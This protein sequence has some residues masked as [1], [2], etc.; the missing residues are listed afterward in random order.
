MKMAVTEAGLQQLRSI[1]MQL[2]DSVKL[3][4][5]GLQNREYLMRVVDN[6]FTR[7]KKNNSKSNINGVFALAVSRVGEPES[8]SSPIRKLDSSKIQA[9]KLGIGVSSF[10]NLDKSPRD[11]VSVDH[12]GSPE[13]SNY[14]AT[15]INKQQVLKF[16][17]RRDSIGKIG[18]ESLAIK[19]NEGSAVL[20]HLKDLQQIGKSHPSKHVKKIV[21]RSVDKYR[22]FERATASNQSMH[23]LLRYVVDDGKPSGE[24]S[25]TLLK[26][27]Y[28]PLMVLC[29]KDY[30]LQ[31]LNIDHEKLDSLV[32]S[33]FM[34]E[35]CVKAK[36]AALS[37][38][39]ES[40]SEK[41]MRRIA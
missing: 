38:I 36:I 29:N 1:D 3:P 21:A 33:K 25:N 6:A 26:Q 20:H 35:D 14:S 4:T 28:S 12:N 15:K 34:D 11:S 24:Q 9:L 40:N 39:S 41:H 30:L 2:T 7:R 22:R 5:V 19:Q 13:A 8:A 18:H 31:S 17:L 32:Q 23:N 27:K 10:N 37:K 16:R